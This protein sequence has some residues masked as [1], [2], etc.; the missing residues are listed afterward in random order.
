MTHVVIQRSIQ[1]CY[2]TYLLPIIDKLDIK[3]FSENISLNILVCC[4]YGL[5][6]PIFIIADKHV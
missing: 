3:K 6:I 4:R 1:N 2:Y 5:M